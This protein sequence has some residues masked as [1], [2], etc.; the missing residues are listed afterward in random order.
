[1]SIPAFS[2]IAK[3][4]N[5][6]SLLWLLQGDYYTLRGLLE[7]RSSLKWLQKQ[8]ANQTFPKF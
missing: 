5:D 1:M 3:S 2:D 6:V 4:A 7:G 8:T